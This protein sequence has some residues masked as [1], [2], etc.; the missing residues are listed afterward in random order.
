[1]HVSTLAR[2][3]D[4]IGYPNPEDP[5][6]GVGPWGPY[7]S[8]LYWALLNPQPLPPKLGGRRIFGP[9]PDPWRS[10]AVSAIVADRLVGMVRVAEGFHVERDAVVSQIEQFVMR[11]VPTR[12]ARD[13]RSRGPVHGRSEPAIPR[14][15][16]LCS[17]PT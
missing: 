10:L 13:G 1:M 14:R 11:S 17:P 16:S 15:T 5:E 8:K 12:L 4:A 2:I 3:F 6:G 9:Q 7:A